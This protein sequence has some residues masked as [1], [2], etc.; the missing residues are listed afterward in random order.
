MKNY[1]QT[2]DCHAVHEEAVNRA[3]Q[4]MPPEETFSGLSDLYRMAADGTRLKILWALQREDMCVCDL[5]V[6]L[7]MTKSA[8]SHQL[9]SLR[10]AALVKFRKQ[11]KV[12]FYSVADN[13]VNGLLG[14]LL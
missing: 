4:V 11:G 10:L 12:V 13:R 1:E 6:L 8:V 7:N 14:E 2:C 9:K 5:A 3:R